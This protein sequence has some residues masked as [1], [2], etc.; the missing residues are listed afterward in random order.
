MVLNCIKYFVEED[1][2][3]NGSA[4]IDTTNLHYYKSHPSLS[5]IFSIHQNRKTVFQKV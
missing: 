5:N 4:Y 2:Q 1:Y 3:P